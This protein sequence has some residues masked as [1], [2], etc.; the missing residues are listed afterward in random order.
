M[1]DAGI[2][3]MAIQCSARRPTTHLLSGWHTTNTAQER[4]NVRVDGEAGIQHHTEGD[5]PVDGVVDKDM[6]G[7]L[8]MVGPT[9]SRG[10]RTCV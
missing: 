2:R 9:T 7:E 8:L 1:E 5:T 3:A 4:R 10:I 6:A